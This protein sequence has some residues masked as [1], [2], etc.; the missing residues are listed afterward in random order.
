MPGRAPWS[1]VF[2]GLEPVTMAAEDDHDVRDLVT[3]GFAGVD[4]QGGMEPHSPGRS[5]CCGDIRS[6]DVGQG[7][8]HPHPRHDPIRRG[9]NPRVLHV[10]RRRGEIGN[11]RR[12]HLYTLPKTIGRYFVGV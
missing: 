10:R 11:V 3:P 6:N 8:L 4:R 12:Q 9:W 2:V 1:P 7:R 5:G